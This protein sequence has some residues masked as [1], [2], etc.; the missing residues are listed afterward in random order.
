MSTINC[1]WQCIT[2]T[3]TVYY[4]YDFFVSMMSTVSFVLGL[5]TNHVVACEMQP[6]VVVVLCGMNNFFISDHTS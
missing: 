5:A 1:C 4:S 6:A 3:W 2:R